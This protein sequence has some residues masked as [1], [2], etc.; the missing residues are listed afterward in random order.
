M[1]VSVIP[2]GTSFSVEPL[3]Y[4]VGDSFR[5]EIK[6]GQ[7]VQI[8]YG[9]KQ[10]FGIVSEVINEDLPSMPKDREIKPIE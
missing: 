9:K 8:P 5:S 6:T 2:F 7:L 4:F 10:I 3:T 1:F